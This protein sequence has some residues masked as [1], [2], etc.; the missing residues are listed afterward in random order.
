MLTQQNLMEFK[1]KAT[2]KWLLFFVFKRKIDTF[3]KKYCK[4]F[5]YLK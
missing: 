5:F 3:G 2:R 4:K 1:R